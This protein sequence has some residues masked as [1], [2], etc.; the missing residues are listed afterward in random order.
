MEALLGAGFLEGAL[1]LGEL[2]GRELGLVFGLGII[3]IFSGL[4]GIAF[5]AGAAGVFGGWGVFLGL[6]GRSGLIGRV[7][8]R[9]LG[10]IGTGFGVLL[11]GRARFG[12]GGDLFG[13]VFLV[14]LGAVFDGF[15]FGGLGGLGDLD[16]L[17]G[18]LGAVGDGFLGVAYREPVFELGA[19]LQLHLG[20][21]EGVLALEAAGGLL[22]FEEVDGFESFVAL[23]DDE[24]G[25]LDAEIVG[26]GHQEGEADVG[27]DGDLGLVR[28]EEGDFGGGLVGDGDNVVD[29]GV[30][31]D[32]AAGGLEL[33]G[34]G[35]GFLDGEGAGEEGGVAGVDLH[36]GLIVGLALAEV[37]IGGNGRLVGLG[38]DSHAG[39]LDGLDA[40]AFDVVSRGDAGVGGEEVVD[41][42]AIDHGGGD[43]FEVVAKGFGVAAR[44]VIVEALAGV[45]EGGLPG[46]VE[47]GAGGEVGGGVILAVVGA[48]V[49]L[50]V[51]G[52]G[53]LDLDGEGD[54]GAGGDASELGIIAGLD[55]DQASVGGADDICQ[56]GATGGVED[57]F[58]GHRGVEAEEDDN[59]GEG[60]GHL[61]EAPL[62]DDGVDLD[63]G[64]V[65]DSLGFYGGEE[66][67]GDVLVVAASKLQIVDQAVFKL[68]V[69]V[70]DGL[71]GVEAVDPADHGEKDLAGDVS[72]S[73]DEAGPEDKAADYQVEAERVV[74]NDLKEEPAQGGRGED[75]DRGDNVGR[76]DPGAGAA[77]LVLDVLLVVEQL[78]D[79][80]GAQSHGACSFGRGPS[81]A[82]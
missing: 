4:F 48:V 22:V 51:C 15:L 36:L 29:D 66:R 69:G 21:V 30:R 80:L 13:G 64:E 32:L 2:F 45:S 19:G 53:A 52:T 11:L 62:I 49:E 26:G 31:V 68:G 37:E 46:V 72:H 33:D 24:K 63:V 61:E 58:G 6:I 18:G 27:G 57:A 39:A 7:E 79:R 74:E 20:E 55:I 8:F 23:A 73:R 78:S 12:S 3:C 47:V 10:G 43:D 76:L 42:D 50:E 67:L 40:A 65:F 75:E 9:F 5:L 38:A 41:L 59:A 25:F 77:D 60:V 82:R 14:F 34:I 44:Q 71:G 16:D 70:F 1:E 28:A 35:A 56:K 17:A 81:F 54:V